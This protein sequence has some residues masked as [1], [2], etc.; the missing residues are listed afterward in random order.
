M[1]EEETVGDSVLAF[2]I[3]ITEFSIEIKNYSYTH[4][5]NNI[6]STL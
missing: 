1:I 5:D 3:R 4:S 2:V 6:T